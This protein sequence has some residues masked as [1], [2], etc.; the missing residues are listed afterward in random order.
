MSASDSTAFATMRA[1]S[2]TWIGWKDCRPSPGTGM[3]QGSAA[4]ARKRAVPPWAP[5]A[6]TNDGR[7][8]T[9][10]RLVPR[11]ASSPASFVAAYA[12]PALASALIA[13]I[14]TTR[15][16]PDTSHAR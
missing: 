15:R 9:Q 10:S 6:W 2:S 14:S 7:R 12:V 8:T 4:S 16:T 5:R 1:R 3:T 13:E 11:S